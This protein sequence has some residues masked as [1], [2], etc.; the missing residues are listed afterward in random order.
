MGVTST[1]GPNMQADDG[2][3]VSNFITSALRKVPLTVYGK[4][5][6]SR[7]FCYVDDLIEGIIKLMEFPN[8]D[9]IH[10]PF[11]IGNSGEYTVK[12]L[13]QAVIDLFPEDSLK[14]KYEGLPVDDPKK[15]KPDI[16]KAVRVL[17]WQPRTKLR[18]G[19]LKTIEY[20][21]SIDQCSTFVKRE[22]VP[23]ESEE[24]VFI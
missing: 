5:E 6:Q 14:I 17:G 23:S 22:V 9:V 12:D 2:R 20:F 1:Y 18:D 10:T 19:L 13:A 21:Q 4:G 3:V 16:S 24:K 8:T 11:N 7:S 15:R